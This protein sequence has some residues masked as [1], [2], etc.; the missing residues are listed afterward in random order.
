MVYFRLESIWNIPGECFLSF[1]K[2]SVR[3]NFF[4]N[5]IISAF[6]RVVGPDDENA[7]HFIK[8][9]Y[10]GFMNHR[11]FLNQINFRNGIKILYLMHLFVFLKKTCFFDRIFSKT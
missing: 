11:D 8:N 9:Q 2:D 4:S 7:V 5:K 10:F 3:N 6:D 1:S